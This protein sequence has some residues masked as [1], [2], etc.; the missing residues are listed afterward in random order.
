VSWKTVV[1]LLDYNSKQYQYHQYETYPPQFYLR[2]CE[3]LN[4]WNYKLK[5]VVKRS[6]CYKK[7][8][9]V[10]VSAFREKFLV[11]NWKNRW[12]CR[13]LNEPSVGRHFSKFLAQLPHLYRGYGRLSY[14][15]SFGFCWK[16]HIERA[17]HI[18]FKRNTALSSIYAY[19]FFLILN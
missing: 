7:L 16:R 6:P 9:Q 8:E 5:C 17:P 12:T 3:T 11:G 4:T 14:F 19:G 15:E 10:K 2:R 18:L 13:K 1:M